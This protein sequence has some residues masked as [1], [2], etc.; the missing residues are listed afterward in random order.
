MRGWF[1]MVKLGSVFVGAATVACTAA[2]AA[3][4]DVG[5]TQGAM[6]AMVTTE[7][8]AM[9]KDGEK[10]TGTATLKC[11]YATDKM[12][13]SLMDS[14]RKGPSCEKKEGKYKILCAA[15]APTNVVCTWAA[16][17]DVKCASGTPSDGCEEKYTDV[18]ADYTG[19]RKLVDI[20]DTDDHLC[21]LPESDKDRPYQLA[22]EC[23]KSLQDKVD[24]PDGGKRLFD[25]LCKTAP[26]VDDKEVAC[27]TAGLAVNPAP[28]PTPITA[29]PT[30]T[31]VDMAPTRTMAAP[32][33]AVMP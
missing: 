1:D 19:L 5:Q 23:E 17:Q 28:T 7:E 8:G 10:K 9:C 22:F 12:H 32:T 24:Y 2:P 3:N 29:T 31:T 4:E 25:G 33:T 20:D 11:T 18:T 14:E 15:W 27:C 26:T 13:S 21:E 16:S 30:V 6:T